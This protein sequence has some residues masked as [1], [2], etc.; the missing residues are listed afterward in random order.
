MIAAQNTVTH[1]PIVR[2]VVIQAK[3]I[4]LTKTARTL[5]RNS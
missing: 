1:W 3:Y 2:T 4:Q 5:I